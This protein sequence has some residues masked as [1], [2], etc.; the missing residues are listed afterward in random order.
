MYPLIPPN[1]FEKDD[2]VYLHIYSVRY[3]CGIL[4]V[5]PVCVGEVYTVPMYSTVHE[6][7]G[8]EMQQDRD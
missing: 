3:M 6:K 7:I 8:T 5:V 1:T 2:D 4:L